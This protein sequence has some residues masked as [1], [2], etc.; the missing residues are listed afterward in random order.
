MKRISPVPMKDQFMNVLAALQVHRGLA[1]LLTWITLFWVSLS[2]LSLHLCRA[3][4]SKNTEVNTLKV[5]VY[6]SS[7]C[8]NK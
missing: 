8:Y 3:Q 1:D 4:I 7:R 5:E 6:F 2:L